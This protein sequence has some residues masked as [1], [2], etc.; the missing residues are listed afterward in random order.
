MSRRS[1]F[2]ALARQAL[3]ADPRMGDVT[4][5]SAWAGN[6]SAD[7]LPVLGVVTAQENVQPES[8]SHFSRST[9]L[10]VV[11]KRLG[12]ADPE[13]DLDDDA[14]AIEACLCPF[15]A[16]QG[17]ML[18]PE[19]VTF[20]LNG[21]GEQKIATITADFRVTWQRTLAGQLL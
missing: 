20:T 18:L 21:E 3:A 9:L 5:I 15:F 13:A 12:G 7:A 19:K 16:A 4:Q 6:I 1:D 17:V 10:Q 11:V 14:D 8:L 2:R